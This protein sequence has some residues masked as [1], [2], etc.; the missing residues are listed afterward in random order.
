MA[1]PASGVN[2]VPVAPG[3]RSAAAPAAEHTNIEGPSPGEDTSAGLIARAAAARAKA[4][5]LSATADK[6]IEEAGELMVEAG[7]KAKEELAAAKANAK[8]L[9]VG[10]SWFGKFW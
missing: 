5:E 9:G 7:K 3:R 8:A 6:L 1:A 10:K 2:A 4:E